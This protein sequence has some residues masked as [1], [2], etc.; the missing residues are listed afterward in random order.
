M[1]EC[2]GIEAYFTDICIKD[3]YVTPSNKNVQDWLR[4]TRG[5]MRNPIRTY[6]GL[7]PLPNRNIPYTGPLTIVQEANL[8]IELN[9]SD[10]VQLSKYIPRKRTRQP[11]EN[12][13]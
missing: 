9:E 8:I 3:R 12:I 2:D 1:S 5:I 6:F 4:Q 7:E 10:K 11:I 13:L